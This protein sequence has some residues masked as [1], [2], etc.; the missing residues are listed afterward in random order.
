MTPAHPRRSPWAA[1]AIVLTASLAVAS[2]VVGFLV[3]PEVQGQAGA[4]V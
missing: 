3:L 2:A 4:G 1:T